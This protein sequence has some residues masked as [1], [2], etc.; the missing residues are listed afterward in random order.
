MPCSW[1]F[2]S[3]MKWTAVLDDLKVHLPY[4]Q[5]SCNPPITLENYL[6]WLLQCSPVHFSQWMDEL[7]GIDQTNLVSYGS[8]WLLRTPFR[9][10]IRLIVMQDIFWTHTRSHV[11]Q[12]CPS[13]RNSNCLKDNETGRQSVNIAKIIHMDPHY[14]SVVI[15]D[16]E[17]PCLL[18]PRYI[19]LSICQGKGHNS[20]RFD[21]LFILA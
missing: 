9:I 8:C 16:G 20:Q 14:Q 18:Q 11:T 4:L 7:D 15:E 10:S 3:S 19:F 6:H 21:P 13:C 17:I 12:W 5:W 1:G 2:V